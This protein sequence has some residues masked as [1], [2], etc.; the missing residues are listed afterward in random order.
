M[1]PFT[2]ATELA[3]AVR[4]REVSPVELAELY[5]G[6]MDKLDPE[7]NAFCFR[8]DD[9]VR[10]EARAA[11]EE[12]TRRSP[13]ELAP[14]HGIPLPIK[15]LNRREGWPTTFGSRGASP[16]PNTVSDVVVQRFVEAGFIPLGMTNSPE[17]G[18]V[19]F[20]ESEAHGVTRNPWDTDHTPGGSS[21]GAAS[22]V[23][24]GMAPIAHASDGGGSIRIPAS[25]CGLVGLKA[26][27][28]RVPN[29]VNEIEGFGTS[30][31]VS[32]TVADT[33]AVLDVIGRPDPLGWY[34][35]P[36]PARPWA[37]TS[38]EAAGPLRIGVTT[39]PPV[40]MPVDPACVQAVD[41]A[42]RALEGMGHSVEEVDLTTLVDANRFVE[43]FGVVWN[44]GSAG[45]PLVDW[46]AIEPLNA[47][48]RK[49][50]RELDSISYVE[51]VALTQLLSR[52]V[53]AP[54][55]TGLDVLVTP[56]MAVEPPRCGSVWE[57]ADVDPM[58]AMFNCFPMGMFTSV[59][60]VTGLPALSLPLH[61]SETGL[62]VGVQFVAGPWREDLLLQLG[63]VLEQAL[64]WADRRPAMAA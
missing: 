25:C 43:A 35:A 18:T 21:G 41:L 62:P 45:V 49:A 9:R 2:P 55:T 6:R 44:T 48:L 60:N 37:E 26:S 29:G 12:V 40:A 47:A 39:T 15:E 61:T 27:R 34:N 8:D 63:T 52:Q 38:L 32:R 1:E 57:G 50:G 19:S 14:F 51:G 53:V 13:E 36:P 7:L 59:W 4:R 28:N 20:T 10:A 23:S 56:T 24:S 3:A 16:E 46:D 31:V 22:A 42:V 17:F 11:A 5:L 58:A 54:F 64:P 30:G 33:A